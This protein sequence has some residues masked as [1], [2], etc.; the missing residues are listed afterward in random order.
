MAFIKG[1]QLADS[2]VTSDKIDLTGSFDFTQGTVQVATPTADSQAATKAYVDQQSSASAEGLTLK[3]PVRVVSTNG[4]DGGTDEWAYSSS[5]KIL[6][7]TTPGQATLTVDGVSLSLNDRVLVTGRGTASENGIYYVSQEGD[8]STTEWELTRAADFDTAAEIDANSFFWVEEGTT[9]A[10]TGWVYKGSSAPTLDTDNI[11]FVQFSS[12]GVVLGG[13]GITKTGNTLDLDF[14]SLT[15]MAS[16]IANGDLLAVE[17]IDDSTTK[18]ITFENLRYRLME[19][20]LGT[21][22]ATLL[23]QD[24][25][26]SDHVLI[27]D[28]S[29][30]AVKKIKADALVVGGINACSVLANGLADGD[31]FAI[32][33]ASAT[34]NRNS[35]TI[36]DIA[37][38][39]AG[40]VDTSLL[41]QTSSVFK[42]DINGLSASGTMEQAA[43]LLAFWDNSASDFKKMSIEQLTDSLF[44][45]PDLTAFTLNASDLFLLRDAD[46]GVNNKVTIDAILSFIGTNSNILSRTALGELSVDLEQVISTTEGGLE[47][48]NN[49]DV[50]GADYF[51]RSKGLSHFEG[52]AA[53]NVSVPGTGSTTIS[54][55]GSPTLP[56]IIGDEQ[57]FVNG[58]MLDKSAYVYTSGATPTLA[59]S[60]SAP[61][62]LETT[63]VVKI[64]GHTN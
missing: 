28:A 52:S 4:I 30:G 5:T 29:V 12:A 11:E 36:G 9:Y 35:A 37:T 2:T 32:S 16:S 34:T 21:D 41:S 48:K 43:D 47:V 31:K 26:S 8:G 54:F 1:K 24:V 53:S 3:S 13:E 22:L 45:N 56:D 38:L 17:D 49:L 27:Y 10:D 40:S 57:V 6:G 19:P 61:F 25:T 64:V 42:V 44:S 18:R 46:G 50:N 60:S 58:I 23:T 39:F 55:S 20:V 33:D 59:W 14:G 62:T 7:E 15:N 63:D 51:I